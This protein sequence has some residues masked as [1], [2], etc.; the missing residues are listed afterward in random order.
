MDSTVH[1]WVT[2]SEPVS[3]VDIGDFSLTTGGEVNGASIV[4]VSGL[5]GVYTVT[6]QTGSGDG[7]IRL[8][9]L[10]DDSIVDQSNQPLGGVG[11]GK[12]E[13]GEEYT[14]VKSP[15][16]YVQTFMS[17]GVNDG[18]VI[19]SS[20][21]SNLGNGYNSIS[22]TF[23]L[24]DNAE[25][26]QF[27]TIL[28]FSTASLPDNAVITRVTLK[29][30]KLSVTGT[31]PFTTHQN[32]QVDIKS[33]SFDAAALQTTDFQAAASMYSAGEI[34]NTPEDN[35]YSTTLDSNAFQYINKLGNT[36]FRLKFELDDND[37]HGADTVK[38]H[39]GNAVIDYRPELL[40]E[41]YILN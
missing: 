13:L 15:K 28:D 40:I 33:G 26:R 18:W 35:W 39:S 22:S 10:D 25:D 21:N 23:Y 41:Y 5:K 14:I 19:E 31:D 36:Q 9:V 3:G 32:V 20:E 30:K 6:V 34:L 37:D 1:F 17:N 29:I 12:F 38:V 2:F 24:G 11:S 27:L 7:T 8:N 4:S 16:M